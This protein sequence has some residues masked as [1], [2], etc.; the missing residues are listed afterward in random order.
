MYDEK[1]A[2]TRRLIEQRDQIDQELRI[3]FGEL[4]QAKRGRRRKADDNSPGEQL[5][6]GADRERSPSNAPES[7]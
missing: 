2:R 5:E 7:P 6:L 3:L 1:L 4:P